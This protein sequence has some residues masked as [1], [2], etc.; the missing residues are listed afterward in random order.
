MKINFNDSIDKFSK[1]TEQVNS[2]LNFIEHITYNNKIKI[3]PV[4]PMLT[5]RSKAARTMISE[6]HTTQTTVFK[7]IIEK[8]PGGASMDSQTQS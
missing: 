2:D 4:L 8:T 1:I 6:Q 7:D 3:S 5:E